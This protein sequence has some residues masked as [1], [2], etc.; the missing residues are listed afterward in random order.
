MPLSEVTQKR[1]RNTFIKKQVFG[2]FLL[3]NLSLEKRNFLPFMIVI[4]CK[5]THEE[6]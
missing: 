5:K 2:M 6:N 1:L 4:K 3:L